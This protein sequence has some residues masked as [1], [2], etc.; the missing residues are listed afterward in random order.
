MS[1][2]FNGR[3]SIPQYLASL[4]DQYNRYLEYGNADFNLAQRFVAYGVWDLPVFKGNKWLG[5]WSYDA[6]FSIQSGQP[7]SVLDDER[8][9]RTRT[10]ITATGQ[11]ISVREAP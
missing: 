1:D 7:F 5:G 11:S 10:A 2:V 4:E 8:R 9:I 6:T 3:F